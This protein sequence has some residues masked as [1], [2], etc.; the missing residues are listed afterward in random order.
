MKDLREQANDAYSRRDF[1]LALELSTQLARKG[2]PDGV[3]TSGLILEHGWHDGVVDLDGA[4][5]FY[6]ELATKF[7]DKEGYLGFARV[8]LKK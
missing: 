6:S 2:L 8:V 7:D 4:L 5:S 3:L 1:K